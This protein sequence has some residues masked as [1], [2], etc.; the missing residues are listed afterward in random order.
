[1]INFE[2]RGLV[3]KIISNIQDYQQQSYKF[4]VVEPLHTFLLELPS[5]PDGTLYKLS[6]V[7]EPR[8]ESAA[9][10][11][12]DSGKGKKKDEKKGKK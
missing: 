7:R 12:K 6:L 9:A 8:Q 5:L 3:H 1:M 10:T 2:K 11:P 4:P